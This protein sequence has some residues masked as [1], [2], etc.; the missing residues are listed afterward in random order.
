[1]GNGQSSTSNN[2]VLEDHAGS[3]PLLAYLADPKLVRFASGQR[4]RGP[5]RP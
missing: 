3:N 4:V 1:M 5:C 2:L